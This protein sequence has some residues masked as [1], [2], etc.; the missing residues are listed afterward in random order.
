[1]AILLDEACFSATDVFLAA[2]RGL[3]RVTLVGTPSGGGSG[4]ARP[5]VLEH[6]RLDLR[7]SSMASFR[8]DG[9]VYDGESVEPDVLVHPSPGW[10]VGR[11]DPVLD[12]ALRRV[13][14]AK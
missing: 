8:P 7:M 6:S 3:P 1:V 14:S 2:F 5:L 9:R 12:E 10:W 4:R 11:E 13:K